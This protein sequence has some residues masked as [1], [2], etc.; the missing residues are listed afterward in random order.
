MHKHG[1]S[2]L[3]YHNGCRHK[4]SGLVWHGNLVFCKCFCW[5]PFPVNFVGRK[6]ANHYRASLG[7]YSSSLGTIFLTSFNWW[8]GIGIERLIDCRGLVGFSN[9]VLVRGTVPQRK[10]VISLLVKGGIWRYL[11]RNFVNT[12]HFISGGFWHSWCPHRHPI[13]I[14][15]KDINI[16]QLESQVDGAVEDRSLWEY[17]SNFASCPDVDLLNMLGI[18]QLRSESY[19]IYI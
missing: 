2:S 13:L 1:T 19:S 12:V 18:W 16:E 3:I 17:L 8:P 11:F 14:E 5:Y 15:R 6:F 4:R 10:W 7:W 9:K